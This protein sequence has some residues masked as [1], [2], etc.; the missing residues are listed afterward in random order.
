MSPAIR[1]SAVLAVTALQLL[2]LAGNAPASRRHSAQEQA[3]RFEDLRLQTLALQRQ[4]DSGQIPRSK[5]NR[6]RLDS[7]TNFAMKALGEARA[8]GQAPPYPHG[9]E[10][11]RLAP[12][13]AR[14]IIQGEDALQQTTGQRE[15]RGDSIR[16]A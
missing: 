1:E 14:R 12:E 13:E 4:M 16:R 7:L 5:R 10:L 15:K 2:G 8:H 3:R 11:N 6:K 9:Q